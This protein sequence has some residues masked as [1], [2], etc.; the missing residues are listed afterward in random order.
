MAELILKAET[1]GS[2]LGDLFLVMSGSDIVGLDFAD[3]REH[4]RCWRER[5]FGDCRVELGDCGD[6]AAGLR[7]YLDGDLA[8]SDA[9][10][11]DAGGTPFQRDV[12]SAMRRVPAGETTTYAN[13]AAAVGRSSGAA[14]AVGHA[15]GANP[16]AILLPCHRVVGTGG[17]LTGFAGGLDRKR[18]LLD[19]E[20]A[21]S[22]LFKKC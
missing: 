20:A 3:R 1:I 5:R 4:G 11:I 8:A 22:G 9:L 17:G 7:A 10:S 13:L 2:P 21:A 16:I 6:A 14:R 15:V 19:H 12:W 18:W